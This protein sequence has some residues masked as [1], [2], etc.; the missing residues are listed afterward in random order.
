M[1]GARAASPTAQGAGTAP[2]ALAAPPASLPAAHPASRPVWGAGGAAHRWRR[3]PWTARRA[4]CTRAAAPPCRWCACW[5]AA[6]AAPTCTG[7]WCAS[8]AR[9]RPP[10]AGA[11]CPGPPRCCCG[12]GHARL[13]PAHAAGAWGAPLAGV[14]HGQGARTRLGARGTHC[15]HLRGPG[16]FPQAG[17]GGEDGTQGQCRP[18]QGRRRLRQGLCPLPDAPWAAAHS[19]KSSPCHRARRKERPWGEADDRAEQGADGD[20]TGGRL[21]RGADG[22]PLRLALQHP[23]HAGEEGGGPVGKGPSSVT[24]VRGVLP[25]L[26]ARRR[27]SN[28]WSPA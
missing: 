23:A 11:G 8:G 10:R 15:A 5:C 16:L 19:V 1:G 21:G 18:R 27:R 25:A 9:A 12:E 14:R 22:R 13:G 26:A 17:G 7:W 28:G 3:P 24:P 4:R 20:A 2:P 6:A